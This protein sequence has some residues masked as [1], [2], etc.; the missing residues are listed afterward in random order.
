MEKLEAAVT[1]QLLTGK[2]QVLF[3]AGP[4]HI[5]STQITPHLLYSHLRK[6]RLNTELDITPLNSLRKGNK[7]SLNLYQLVVRFTERRAEMGIA[8]FLQLEIFS[9]GP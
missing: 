7:I 5:Y 4:A 6:H 2:Q 8:I 3:P 1:R 9:F